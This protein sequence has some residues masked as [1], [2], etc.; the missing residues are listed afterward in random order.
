M[1]PEGGGAGAWADLAGGVAG[2]QLLLRDGGVRPVA[3]WGS[4]A[5]FNDAF[6]VTRRARTAVGRTGAGGVLLVTV[7]EGAGWSSGLSLPELATTLVSLGVADAVNLDGG[8]STTPVR[9]G[10][11]VNRPSQTGRAV[12]DGLFVFYYPGRAPEPGPEPEPE[13]EPEGAGGDER[14]RSDADDAD[15]ESGVSEGGVG[16]GDERNGGS[17]SDGPNGALGGTWLGLE[18]EVGQLSVAC[19]RLVPGFSA[20][21]AVAGL[22]GEQVAIEVSYNPTLFEG[23]CDVIDGVAEFT[24][25][26]S[27]GSAGERLVFTLDGELLD[28]G[29]LFTVETLA[30][31]PADPPEDA[32]PEED[33]VGKPAVRTPD[34]ELLAGGVELGARPAERSVPWWLWATM[35]AGLESF[36][37]GGTPVA[38]PCVGR[39]VRARSR[40][41]GA[42]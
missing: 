22:T 1:E 34:A 28:M 38:Q 18:V 30:E 35:T 6:P 32:E 12:A 10:Q 9:E 42:C 41:T 3:E 16:E 24:L 27:E 33:V 23:T 14:S 31:A 21:C 7:D 8:G 5:A 36:V 17:D 13:P 20:R 19:N 39:A 15:T 25:P 4:F 29:E 40:G 2:G 26:L 11:V 37:G